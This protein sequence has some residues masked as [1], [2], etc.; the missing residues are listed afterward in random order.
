VDSESLK[1][2]WHWWSKRNTAEN[3]ELSVLA[4]VE[5]GASIGLYI[6]LVLQGFTLQLVLAAA[7]APLLLLRTQMS[8]ELG[9]HYSNQCAQFVE[10]YVPKPNKANSVLFVV[11]SLI[12]ALA[13]PFLMI[14]FIGA[15]LIATVV[16]ASS[17]PLR[18]ILAI[19]DNW[20]RV[21]GCSDFAVA[22]DFIPGVRDFEDRT[23]VVRLCNPI[24]SFIEILSSHKR[25]SRYHKAVIVAMLSPSL[26]VS[27]FY[28][29]SLK[30]S[31]L[32]YLPLI[33]MTRGS[34]NKGNDE[35]DD[36][37]KLSRAWVDRSKIEL[38]VLAVDYV[39]Q[40]LSV[41]II[42]MFAVK[43][44][45]PTFVIELV[46]QI[47]EYDRIGLSV[48]FI[49]PQIFP[50]WQVATLVNSIIILV[51]FRMR[52][53][54]KGGLEED[55]SVFN[56]TLVISRLLGIVVKLLALYVTLVTIYNISTL[57]WTLPLIEERWFPWQ[58]ETKLN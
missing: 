35:S 10:G 19:P 25:L 3:M 2:K 42:A 39:R 37:L 8:I 12:S 31:S 11:Q 53:L 32:I 55:G 5:T 57:E 34:T 16:A 58:N 21:I 45:F 23:P 22:P 41:I 52:R 47:S 6:W 24:R 30:G 43:Y 17:Y 14:C 28:R 56:L 26:I 40:V 20:W 44:F 13:M 54:I 29:I 48:L 18:S 51:I 38:E 50:R 49:A 7:I 33:W 15:K 1:I 27:I 4:L 46:D 36:S 9:V